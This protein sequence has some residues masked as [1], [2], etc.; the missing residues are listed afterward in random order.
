[1]SQE[2]MYL[3]AVMIL[4]GRL[5][6]TEELVTTYQLP[7]QAPGC[8]VLHA[9]R[10]LQAGVELHKFLGHSINSDRSLERRS[11]GAVFT[12]CLLLVWL[13]F[14]LTVQQAGLV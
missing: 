14:Y 7:E 9:R 13:C 12:R 6:H 1:M 10:D 2:N 11:I 5:I 3:R 4:T 8:A